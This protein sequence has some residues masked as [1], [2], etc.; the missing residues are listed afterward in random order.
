MFMSMAER[1]VNQALEKYKRLGVEETTLVEEILW[2]ESFVQS[3]V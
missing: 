2:S 1:L 3:R